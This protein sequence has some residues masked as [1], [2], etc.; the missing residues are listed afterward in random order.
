MKFS[1]RIERAEPSLTVTLNLRARELAA[2]GR[3][4][5]NLTAGEPDFPTPAPIIAATTRALQDGHTRY[6]TPGG[7]V[8]LRQAVARRIE[9]D[10]GLTSE[11]DNIL[12]GAGAKQLLFHI[13]QAIIND[14]DE[15][16][17]PTPAWVSYDAQIRLAGGQ[18]RAIPLYPGRERLPINRALLDEHSTPRTRA[19]VLTSPNNPAGYILERQELEEIAAW[20]N[21]RDVWIIS[22]EIY[23]CYAFDRPALSPAA[24]SPAM[25][26]RTIL[27][28][29]LSKAYAMTGFRVGYLRANPELTRRVRILL[30][31]AI[32]CIPG[33]IEEAACVAL[34]AGPSLIT[35]E[36]NSI[37]ERR[38]L[39]VRL[40]QPLQGARLIPPEG[41]F[42]AWID[43]REHLQ[44]RGLPGTLR[45]CENILENQSVAL[46]P[47]EAFG[48]PGF[49]R[50]SYAAA[51]PDLEKGIA[52]LL[53]ALAE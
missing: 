28:S 46:I 24:L 20:A 15:V 2:E 37:K 12:I 48:A 22:D 9:A 27:V 47:G 50:L 34:T 3:V 36:I 5:H 35:K 49:L 13:F 32:T 25:A 43:V 8:P 16:L 41:A 52:G 19:L 39:T 7:S 33:F 18:V 6:G 10:T 40:L 45:L 11:P 17:M 26:A 14:G 29:G 31:H 38:D 44:R 53:A 23:S 51:R 1:D 30:S 42:Y 21:D 4:I